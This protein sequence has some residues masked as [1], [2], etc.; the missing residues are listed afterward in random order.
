MAPV[1]WHPNTLVSGGRVL[2]FRFSG[3]RFGILALVE[4]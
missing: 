3:L 1:A 2:G 4:T